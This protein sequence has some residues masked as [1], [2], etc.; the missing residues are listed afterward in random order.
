MGNDSSVDDKQYLFL[1]RHGDRWDYAN[2]EWKEVPESRKGDSPLSLLGHRQAREFG[3]YLDSWMH[4]R[5][6]TGDDI[7]WLS[8]PFL[9]CMQTSEEALNAFEK[10]DLRT[11]EINPEYS[12]FEWDGKFGGWHSDLPS[13]E[14]RRHYFPR[15]NMSYESNFIPELPEPKSKFLKRCQRT[16]DCFHKRHP[17]KKR[18]II[19]MVSHAAGCIALSKAF[20]QQQFSDITPAGPCSIYGLTRTKETNVWSIAAHDDLTG[21]NGFTGHLSDMGTATRPWNK[22]GDGSDVNKKFYTGPPTSR[23]APA[24]LDAKM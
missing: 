3:Q 1:V 2:P 13:L 8:S 22:F 21:H 4:E 10:V 17:F 15:L 12:I 11:T 6:F 7:T 16:V 5:G 23:F 19:V 18:Q 9:R 14:E 20:S 24:K